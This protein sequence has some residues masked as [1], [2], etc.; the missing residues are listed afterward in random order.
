MLGVSHVKVGVQ[1]P[2]STQCSSCTTR[3]SRI[4]SA[5]ASKGSWV[6]R[7]RSLDRPVRRWF[8]RS[9]LPATT[10]SWDSDRR[11]V[12]SIGHFVA[13]IPTTRSCAPTARGIGRKKEAVAGEYEWRTKTAGY[14]SEPPFYVLNGTAS[15]SWGL[16]ATPTAT[17]RPVSRSSAR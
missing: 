15:R 8:D 11:L 13:L 6:C 17:A 5:S 7:G 3:S 12:R 1:C 10:Q 16:R 2:G 14:P 4:S 9:P